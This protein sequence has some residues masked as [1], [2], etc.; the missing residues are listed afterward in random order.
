MDGAAFESDDPGVRA[1]DAA[2][3]QLPTLRGVHGQGGR[4]AR[5]HGRCLLKDTRDAKWL[6]NSN[7]NV[8]LML[9]IQSFG[10]NALDLW[11]Q[12]FRFN[13][14]NTILSVQYSGYNPP[15]SMLHGFNPLGSILLTPYAM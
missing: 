10:F 9:W 12:S 11:I 13:T 7:R 14:L 2:D 4:A 1:E 15:G 5:R 6:I 3:A 8:G